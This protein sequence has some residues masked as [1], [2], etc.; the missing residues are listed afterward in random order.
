VVARKTLKKLA[1]ALIEEGIMNR[2]LAISPIPLLTRILQGEASQNATQEV[3][4]AS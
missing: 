4:Q 1:E 2:T 3:I